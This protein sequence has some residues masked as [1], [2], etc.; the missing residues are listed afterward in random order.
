MSGRSSLRVQKYKSGSKLFKQ[1]NKK[2]TLAFRITLI[3]VINPWSHASCAPDNNIARWKITILNSM[4]ND[5]LWNSG[6]KSTKPKLALFYFTPSI[7]VSVR[8]YQITFANNTD[9]LIA[10]EK[11]TTHIFQ[12]NQ[13]NIPDI[14]LTFWKNDESYSKGCAVDLVIKCWRLLIFSTEYSKSKL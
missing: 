9:S 6:L 10:E 4:G 14:L 1:K 12:D 7:P 11:Q 5:I 2:K 13:H 3:P 8:L